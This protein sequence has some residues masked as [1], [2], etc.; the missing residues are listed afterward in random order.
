MTILFYFF[1]INNLYNYL[2]ADI[3]TTYYIL[4][5]YT[6]YKLK[7]IINAIDL[8]IYVIFIENKI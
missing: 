7:M 2:I 4:Y 1:K 3:I 5:T 6:F 8:F